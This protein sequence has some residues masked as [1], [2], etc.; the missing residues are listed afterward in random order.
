MKQITRF[1]LKEEGMALLIRLPPCCVNACW[2]R[3]AAGESVHGAR[4]SVWR[5]PTVIILTHLERR[6]QR[7]PVMVPGTLYGM[8][9]LLNSDCG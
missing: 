1:L 6:K 3:C 5:P 7:S 2:P 8:K 4:L 9:G